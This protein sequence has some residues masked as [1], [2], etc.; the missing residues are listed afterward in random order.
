MILANKNPDKYLLP[1]MIA[2]EAH[3]AD[4]RCRI[5]MDDADDESMQEAYRN[6]LTTSMRRLSHVMTTMPDANATSRVNTGILYEAYMPLI[7]RY[8]ALLHNHTRDVVVRRAMPREDDPR[9]GMLHPNNVEQLERI[10]NDLVLEFPHLTN[11]DT[12]YY[13]QLKIATDE[14]MEKRGK[15]YHP[16]I[17]EYN[18]HSNERDLRKHLI[19]TLQAM[20][21]SLDGNDVTNTD[22]RR[23]NAEFYRTSSLFPWEIE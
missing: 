19:E 15:S 1:Q 17:C 18:A 3:I 22:K 2:A 23:I 9:D 14:I 11:A 21:K 16:G 8:F 7:V 12:R 13:V 20:I 10:S 4:I 5:I 6:Q